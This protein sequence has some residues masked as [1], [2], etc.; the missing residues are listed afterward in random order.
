MEW[1]GR[2]DWK[3]KQNAIAE[4]AGELKMP[5]RAVVDFGRSTI[6]PIPP[7]KTR[8]NEQYDDRLLQ[9]LKRA[10]PAD[11][12][13]QELI[14]TEADMDAAHERSLNR[15]SI[16]DILHNYVLSEVQPLQVRENIIPFDDVI[17]AGNHFVA[18]RQFM[19][20][21]FPGRKIIGVFVARRVIP[22]VS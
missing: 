1:K 7:S 11:A 19:E 20:Q 13:I 8:A 5:L 14:L 21:Y 18:C 4:I 9:I 15:P 12:D 6:V 2:P 22:A 10:C 16:G 3:Y 17:S